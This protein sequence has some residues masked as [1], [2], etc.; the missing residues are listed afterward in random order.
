MT[1]HPS[2]PPPDREFSQDSIRIFSVLR[3]HVGRANLISSK[4]IARSLRWS[5][6]CARKVRRIISRDGRYWGKPGDLT[7][8]CAVP[9]HGYFIAETFDE[10]ES[11]HNWLSKQFASF[12]NQKR[13]FEQLCKNLGI[14]LND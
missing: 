8:L 6:G 10:I 14:R 9:G 4:S 2:S 11:Y 3:Q 12:R 5:P 13:S 1:P 7:V